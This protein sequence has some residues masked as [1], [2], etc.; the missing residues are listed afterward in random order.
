MRVKRGYV[1]RRRHNRWLKLA[2][3]QYGS[4]HALWKTAHQSV[5]KA[6]ANAYSG[7][8]ARKGDFRRLWITR[9]SAA[10]KANDTSYSSFMHGLDLANIRLN[11]KMLSEIAISDPAQFTHLVEL[12]NAAIGER[13]RKIT[14]PS[15]A[16]V[17]KVAPRAAVL[18][19]KQKVKSVKPQAVT[20]APK[21]E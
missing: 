8:R 20:E 3:G 16:A 4:R 14:A 21:T 17:T 5:I 10:C 15:A 12:A 13:A 11:R 19:A 6:L 7:R 1:L 2:K 9:I 18:P